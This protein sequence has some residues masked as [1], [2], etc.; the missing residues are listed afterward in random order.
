MAPDFAGKTALITGAGRGIG[1]AIALGLADAGAGLILLAR[2]PGQ[3]DEARALLLDRG[4]EAARIRVIPADLGDEEQRVR[5]A[6]VALEAG[7]RRHPDQQRGHG[8][9]ARRHRGHSRRGTAPGLR[10]QRPWPRSRLPQPSCRACSTPGGAASSTSPAGI[11]DRPGTMV[12]GNA[13]AA[14]KAALEAHYR[15]PGRRA[16]RHGRH[17][18]RLPARGS[19]HG[20][21]GAHPRARPGAHRDRTAHALQPELHRGRPDHPGAV[22]RRADRPPRRGRHRIHLGRQR[23]SGPR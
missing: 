22:C 1:R 14:T 19:G 18:Q 4:A 20:D 23:L 15:Q 21:A 16:E 6:G 8:G 11:V 17:G 12:R 9:T 10:A 13:Y 2:S 5:A 7:P 3:L